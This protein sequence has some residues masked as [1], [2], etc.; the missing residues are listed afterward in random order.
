MS[1]IT[2]WLLVAFTYHFGGGSSSVQPSVV[3]RFWTQAECRR[4]QKVIEETD[5][6]VRLRC[7]ERSGQ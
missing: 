6:R 4:V 3:D 1:G 2:V 5:K 7:I